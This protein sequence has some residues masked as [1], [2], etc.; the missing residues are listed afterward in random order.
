MRTILRIVS[1]GIDRGL[2]DK[3]VLNE[4]LAEQLLPTKSGLNYIQRIRRLKER[5]K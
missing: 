2:D 5:A 4:V 3:A 1:D